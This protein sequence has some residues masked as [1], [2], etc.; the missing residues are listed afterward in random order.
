MSSFNARNRTFNSL[1]MMVY[2]MRNRIHHGTGIKDDKQESSDF[3]CLKHERRNFSFE[4]RLQI[5]IRN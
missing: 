5:S 1:A 3:L 2:Q 4:I